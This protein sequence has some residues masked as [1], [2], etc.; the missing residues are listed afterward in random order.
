M[1]GMNHQHQ[2][3]YDSRNDGGNILETN[4]LVTIVNGES[5]STIKSCSGNKLVVKLLEIIGSN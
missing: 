3:S 5:R 2:V 4:G 1:G